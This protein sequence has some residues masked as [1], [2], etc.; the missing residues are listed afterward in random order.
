MKHR[1]NALRFD[2][3]TLSSDVEAKNKL[4]VAGLHKVVRC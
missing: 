2:I 3:V 1:K 4:V